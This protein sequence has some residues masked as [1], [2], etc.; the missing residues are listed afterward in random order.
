MIATNEIFLFDSE[1]E[2]VKECIVVRKEQIKLLLETA[3][4]ND[5][6]SKEWNEFKLFQLEKL[7]KKLTKMFYNY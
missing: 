7:E 6:I 5:S 1:Y 3:N 4:S 2:L